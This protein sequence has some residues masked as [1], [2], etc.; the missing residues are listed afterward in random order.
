MERK[1][2]KDGRE[3]TSKSTGPVLKPWKR[4]I[5]LKFEDSN[6]HREMGQQ[7]DNWRGQASNVCFCLS[8]DGISVTPQNVLAFLFSVSLGHKTLT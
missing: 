4:V 3:E 2:T 5:W 8:R 6:K 1:A 7:P